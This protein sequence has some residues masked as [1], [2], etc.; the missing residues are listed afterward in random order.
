M[1][2]TPT[3]GPSKEAF[4][5]FALSAHMRGGHFALATFD[6]SFYEMDHPSVFLHPKFDS[7][8]PHEIHGELVSC[9]HASLQLISHKSC[10]LTDFRH[11]SLT[12]VTGAMPCSYVYFVRCQVTD[13]FFLFLF[14][15]DVQM[16]R[17]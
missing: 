15:C 5:K 1:N 16:K 4:R 3:Y 2:H 9:G 12:L 8:Q 13:V 6:Q 10:Q 14:K 11:N 17:G 7:E